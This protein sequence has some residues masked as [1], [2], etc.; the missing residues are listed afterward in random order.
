MASDP[1]KGTA[2][3]RGRL[4]VEKKG[5]DSSR[6]EGLVARCGVLTKGLRV[7]AEL[8]SGALPHFQS[9]GKQEHAE[10]SVCETPGA[11]DHVD[12][13]WQALEDCI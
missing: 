5:S 10:L 2:A 1:S 11:C 12:A 3:A 6:R 7:P 4:P 9:V 8:A 13:K